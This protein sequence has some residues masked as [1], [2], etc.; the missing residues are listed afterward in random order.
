MKADARPV[1]LDLFRIAL[2]PMG[3][4]SILHRVSGAVLFLVL[5]LAVWALAESLSGEAGYTRMAALFGHPLTKL[6]VLGLIWA[7]AHHWFAG[8]RHLALDGHLGLARDVARR[9][10]YLI[11][12]AGGVVAAIAAWRLFL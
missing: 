3:W 1:Y 11:L 2:S 8:L 4:V 7:L 9:N 12:A 6:V 5:P 10:S